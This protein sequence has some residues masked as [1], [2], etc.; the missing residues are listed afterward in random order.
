MNDPDSTVVEQTGEGRTHGFGRGQRLA[1]LHELTDVGYEARDGGELPGLPA[2]GGGVGEGPDD[3][4]AVR[5][6]QAH[7][8]AVLRTGVAQAVVVHQRGLQLLLG[9]QV[10]D[11]HQAA[12]GQPA[13][14][15]QAFVPRVVELEVAALQVLPALAA[16]VEAG[17]QDADVMAGTLGD[18]QLVAAHVAGVVDK[19]GGSG[20]VGVV[21]HGLVQG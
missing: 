6:V 7:V 17:E 8:Q 2:A 11:V 15:R 20:P 19:S 1:H 14:A 5:P 18:H 9:V 3:A 21:E 13:Q 10:G 16:L 12:V 4:Q